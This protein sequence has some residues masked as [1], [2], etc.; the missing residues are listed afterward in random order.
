VL[1][2]HDA[3]SRQHDPVTSRPRLGIL[4]LPDRQRTATTLRRRA[5]PSRRSVRS[6]RSARGRAP[7]SGRAP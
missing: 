7:V 5:I 2:V 4:T 3:Q 1:R 6:S